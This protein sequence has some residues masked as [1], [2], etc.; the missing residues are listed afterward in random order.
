MKINEIKSI[1]Q[2][3]V[4]LDLET[5]GLNPFTAEIL[6]LGAIKIENDKITSF[7]TFVK[8]KK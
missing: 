1:V 8:N 7:H 4:F 2:N 6:E 3:V 5:S